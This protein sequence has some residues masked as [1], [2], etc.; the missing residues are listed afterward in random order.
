VAYKTSCLICFCALGGQVPVERI[1]ER[2]VVKEVSVE[3]VVK[4]EASFRV[5]PRETRRLA[6]RDHALG[7]ITP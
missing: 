1:V 2:D 5:A 4:S 6:G 3:R 7:G